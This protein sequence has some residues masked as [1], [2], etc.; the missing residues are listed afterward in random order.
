MN[1][2][3][4]GKHLTTTQRIYIEKGLIDNKSFAEIGRDIN[5]HPSTISKEVKKYRCFAEPINKGARNPCYRRESCQVRLLCEGCKTYKLCKMCFVPDRKDGCHAV[6]PE[7]KPKTCRRVRKAPYVCNGCQKQRT[8]SLPRAF[9]SAQQADLSYRELLV[10]AR[11]GIN[12]SAADIEMLDR[13]IS[14]LLKQGQSIAH[15]YANHG[16][17]IPCSRRT[18]YH[19]IDKGVFEA[20]NIDL[21]RKV[22]Y[23]TKERK[24]GTRISLAARKFR[25]GRT[26]EE[27][28][29]MLKTYPESNVVEMDTVEGGKGNGKQVFLTLFFRNC[30]LM[31][32]IVLPEKTQDHV[33][34]VFDTLSEELGI[35]VFRE[36]FPV[37]LTDNGV[38][39]QF[40]ERLEKDK[41]GNSRTSIYYCNPNCS[42]QKGRLEKNHAYIRCVVPKGKSLDAYDQNDATKLMNHINSEARDSL[43]GSTPFKLSR[44]LLNHKLHRLLKLKEIKAD[45]VTLKPI[46]LDK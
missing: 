2:Q 11:D 42:W 1:N 32:I 40:P 20:R 4:N 34:E 16:H 29:K 38:E 33:I 37:I 39:F 26:Y 31:L 22:R 27:F 35:N 9:Y 28:Q 15:I 43:N 7:F 44:L 14:P 5:K 19:Y 36:L 45:D 6:C 30:S 25:I 3:Y 18:L 12:Q 24:R 23:K 46:L 10:A 13:L 17:E 41:K 8:C 21:R